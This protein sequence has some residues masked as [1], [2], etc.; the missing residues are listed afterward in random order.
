MTRR[1]NSAGAGS[2]KASASTPARGAD[3]GL[4]SKSLL[5][6]LLP[7]WRGRGIEHRARGS[8]YTLI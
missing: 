4:R 3:C 7:K 1:E 5:S 8:P 2:C 6:G